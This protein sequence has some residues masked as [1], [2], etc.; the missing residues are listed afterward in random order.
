MSDSKMGAKVRGLLDT[1]DSYEAEGNLAAAATYRAKA[2]ELMVKYRIEQEEAIAVDPGAVKPVQRDLDLVGMGSKY[3]NTY[4]VMWWHIARHCEV[5]SWVE[6]V[7][8]EQGYKLVAH[9][10]GYEDD[11]RYAEMLFTSARL[12][13]TERLEPR[14]DGSLTDQVNVYRLRSAGLE[15]VRISEMMWGNTDKV[16][17]ARVG[18][19]YKAECEARG[20][21]V[22][23]SGRGVTGKAYREQYAEQFCVTLSSR[24]WQ[25]RQAATASGGGLVLHG[26]KERITEAFYAF[27][28]KLRPA[29]ALPAAEE[30]EPCAKCAQSKRGQCREHYVPMG[31]VPRGPS[32]DTVAAE[33]G[34][35]AGRAAAREVGLNRGGGREALGG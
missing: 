27:Y 2:E 6:Y 29:P 20:E 30:P 5:E 12:V 31:R 32:Y 3:R 14:I 28:P 22:L 33:R 1:A 8:T 34:R 18:R 15:R 13:F 11:I 7:Y 26:R 23:L 35:M 10:V 4:H 16:F 24:L 21:E 17:L 9:V 25:A 19:L